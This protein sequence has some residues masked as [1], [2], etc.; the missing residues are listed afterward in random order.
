MNISYYN[1]LAYL[2]YAV[3][4]NDPVLHAYSTNSL[5]KVTM[6]EEKYSIEIW[7]LEHVGLMAA[8]LDCST[9]SD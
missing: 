2:L 7:S 8:V 5:T 1:F 9:F 3:L 6:S 4:E